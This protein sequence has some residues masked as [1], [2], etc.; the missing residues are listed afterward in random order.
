MGSILHTLRRAHYSTEYEANIQH[1]PNLSTG[2]GWSNCRN[3]VSA[4]MTTVNW[5]LWQCDS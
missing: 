1:S 3:T 4:L 2:T 5:C